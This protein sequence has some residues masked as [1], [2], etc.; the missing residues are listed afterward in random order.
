ML[1]IHQPVEGNKQFR[2]VSLAHV[3][4]KNMIIAVICITIASMSWLLLSCALLLLL[5]AWIVVIIIMNINEYK[6]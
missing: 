2:P 5:L 6:L 1:S 4:R 3:W